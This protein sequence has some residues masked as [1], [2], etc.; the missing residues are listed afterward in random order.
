MNKAQLSTIKITTI[1]NTLKTTQ[2][3]PERLDGL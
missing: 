3:R 1:K 2:E